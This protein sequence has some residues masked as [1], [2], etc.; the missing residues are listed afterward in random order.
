MKKVVYI[1]SVVRWNIE[2]INYILENPERMGSGSKEQWE[3][4]KKEL[5]DLLKTPY[6]IEEEK[7]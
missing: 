2:Q 1:P 7:P 4:R 3:K 6:I 5:E